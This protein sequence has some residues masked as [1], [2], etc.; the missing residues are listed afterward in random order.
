M[1]LLSQYCSKGNLICKELDDYVLMR[2]K[3][4][5]EIMN[6]HK[7]PRKTAKELVLVMMYGENLNEYSCNNGFVIEKPLPKWI[8]IFESEFKTLIKMV[9][10]L[11][12]TI[13]KDVKKLK[14]KDYINKESSCLS[15]VLQQIEDNIIINATT[16]LTHMGYTVETLCFDGALI[17]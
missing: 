15:Y 3:R 7:V 14:K 16:K 4:L 1:V 6:E 17:L 12:E 11:N 2:T 9:C 10:S 5:H 8:D 13:Y